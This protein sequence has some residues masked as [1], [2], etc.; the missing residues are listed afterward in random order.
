MT[1]IIAIKI[2][3]ILC[4]NIYENLWYKRYNVNAFIHRD[5]SYS[6]YLK[7]SIQKIAYL[8]NNDLEKNTY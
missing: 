7:K 4:K 3:I 8:K 6:K 2:I 1:T 5:N